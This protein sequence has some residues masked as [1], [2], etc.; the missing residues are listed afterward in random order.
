MGKNPVEQ[1][2]QFQLCLR[3]GYITGVRK[4]DVRACECFAPNI[5]SFSLFRS[6]NNRAKR[7][8]ISEIIVN[9]VPLLHT[10]HLLSPATAMSEAAAEG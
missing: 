1:T 7:S 4:T 3:Q 8:C 5:L 10:V 6:A 9:D 2:D